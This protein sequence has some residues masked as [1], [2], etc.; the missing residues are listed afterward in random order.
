MQS[1]KS[2][3]AKTVITQPRGGKGEKKKINGRQVS[4]WKSEQNT[5]YIFIRRT[6]IYKSI[7]YTYT[8]LHSNKSHTHRYINNAHEH[9]SIDTQ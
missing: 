7:T 4:G 9:T 1:I 5:G 2:S 8:L 6:Y 3:G